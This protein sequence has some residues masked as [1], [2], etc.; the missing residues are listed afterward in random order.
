MIVVVMEIEGRARVSVG[1]RG[2]RGGRRIGPLPQGAAALAMEIVRRHRAGVDVRLPP[3]R[4]R[5]AVRRSRGG[6]G[7][8]P[9]SLLA[10]RARR[11]VVAGLAV[12]GRRS[13]IVIISAAFI[14]MTVA[15]LPAAAS[16]AV[17]DE[18]VAA[19]ARHLVAGATPRWRGSARLAGV[20]VELYAQPEASSKHSIHSDQPPLAPPS[21]SPLP[22]AARAGEAEVFDD[23]DDAHAPDGGLPDG[24]A[25]GQ[26][27]PSLPPSPPSPPKI[28]RTAPTPP[29]SERCAAVGALAAATGRAPTNG[30]P[31][32]AEAAP[33]IARPKGFGLE[34]DAAAGAAPVIARLKRF[35]LD[36]LTVSGA[37]RAAAAR[38][39]PPPRVSIS[40]RRVLDEPRVVP[41][42]QPRELARGARGLAGRAC[43][44]D[45]GER[46][47]HIVAQH[48][49][50]RH[51]RAEPAESAVLAVRR[52]AGG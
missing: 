47:A 26:L 36:R 30:A 44:L 15:Q 12:L 49:A 11:P 42:Q 10:A 34:R 19:L 27:L 5:R 37:P 46:G 18:R 28:A 23:D 13:R 52:N 8:R 29:V 33:V 20:R 45:L 7:L 24:D 43:A 4:Q 6:R 41:P 2:A 50:R 14:I 22:T 51:G 16:A 40:C 21:S 38:S 9:P 25:D 31:S 3:G 48:D 39:P 32:A 35:G 17:R 1:A